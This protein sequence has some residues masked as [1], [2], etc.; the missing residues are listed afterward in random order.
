MAEDAERRLA[1]IA[2]VGGLGGGYRIA[3]KDLEIRGAGNLL[4]AEQHG[5][6]MEVGFDM[7]CRLLREAVGELSDEEPSSR[8]ST[9]LE[10]D[11][12]AYLPDDYVEDPE[13]RILIYR[14]LV[15]MQQGE[16]VDDLRE[17]LLDRFGLLATPASH[18]LGL[19]EVKLMAEGSGVE[20]VVLKGRRLRLVFTPH[21]PPPRQAVEEMVS[22]IGFP[23]AFSSRRA[24]SVEIDLP[25]DDPEGRISLAKKAL[26]P[27]VACASLDEH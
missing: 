6:M 8:I 10:V 14:R 21:H 7:Y 27:F 4:G 5:F 1:T 19:Q 22:E 18:L 17:E 20:I 23:I 13:E 9:R 2:E 3:L 11:I 16:E 15:G 12:P 25:G 24:F 26:K